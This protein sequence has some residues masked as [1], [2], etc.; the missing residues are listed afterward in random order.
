MLAGRGLV[1]HLGSYVFEESTWEKGR[2]WKDGERR[3]GVD[4]MMMI[5]LF[6]PREVVCV[7][8]RG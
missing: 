6:L 8:L 4:Y 5:V 3:V 1:F 2:R 7:F